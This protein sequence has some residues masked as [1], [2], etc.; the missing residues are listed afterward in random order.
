M[1]V[2]YSNI[3][4]V[5]ILPHYVNVFGGGVL[6]KESVFAANGTSVLSKHHINDSLHPKN[7]S[8]KLTRAKFMA[9]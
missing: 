3:A 1:Y 8:R 2:Y 9:S 7:T 5:C 4:C 6:T